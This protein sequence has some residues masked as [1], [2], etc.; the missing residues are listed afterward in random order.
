MTPTNAV[1][2]APKKAVVVPPPVAEVTTIPA[3]VKV[4][5]VVQPVATSTPAPQAKAPA[6]VT[7]VVSNAL[8]AVG[9]NPFVSPD[10]AKIPLGS[11]ATSVLLAAAR[12]QEEVVLPSNFGRMFDTLEPLNQQT[13]EQLRLLAQDMREDPEV[14]PVA[15]PKGTTAGITFF[16]Q[17][18]D[19]DLTLDTRRNLTPRW[20]PRP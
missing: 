14:P 4:A 7:E 16:G 11:L 19:H 18:I 20:I 9:L 10:P 3:T 13:N 12:K 15:N 8:G 5:A 1:V 6:A 17:F 2:V